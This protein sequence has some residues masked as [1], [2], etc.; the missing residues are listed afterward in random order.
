MA[1]G[2][3]AHPP[4]PAT[5]DDPRRHGRRGSSPPT[6]SSPGPGHGHRAETGR[7]HDAGAAPLGERAQL[8]REAGQPGQGRGAAD[9][10]RARVRADL[11]DLA[12]LGVQ[13]ADDRADVVGRA[14]ELQAHPGL[15]QLHAQLRQ[16]RAHGE[17]A[18]RREGALVGVLDVHAAVDQGRLDADDA[19]ARRPPAREFGAHAGL[20]RGEE[21]AIHGAALQR[22]REA[23]LV[24][25]R[26]L[27]LRQ[28]TEGDQHVAERARSAALVRVASAHR[29]RA[30]DALAAADL[31]RAERHAHTVLVLEAVGEDLQVELAHAADHQLAGLG[32]DA[33]PEG[34]V[35]ARE[36]REGLAQGLLVRGGQRLDRHADDRFDEGD[37]FEDGLV[38]GRAERVAGRRVADAHHRAEVAGADRCDAGALR[39][40]H[41]HQAR[42]ALRRAS[43]GAPHAVARAQRPLV[44]AAE[45]EF[46]MGRAHHLEDQGAQRQRRVRHQHRAGVV[47][48]TA[49]RAGDD[50]TGLGRARQQV[51]HR[52]QQGLDADGRQRRTAQHRVQRAAPHRRAQA[53]EDLVGREVAAGVPAREQRV[54]LGRHRL[55]QLPPPTL[56]ALALRCGQGRARPRALVVAAEAMDLAVEHVDDAFQ[57]AAAAERVGQHHRPRA[58]AGAQLLEHARDV[59]AGAVGLVDEHQARH[60]VARR[61]APHRLGLG[62]DAGD[63]A[64]H[65]HR[66]VEHAAAAL[67]LGG[68]VDV[69]GR[70]DEVEVVVAPRHGGD[71]RLDG[72]ALLAFEGIVIHGGGAVVDLAHLVDAAGQEQD[73]FADR[74]L[75][76]VDVGDDAEVAEPGV[77]DHGKLAGAVRPAALRGPEVLG[78]S[79]GTRPPGS[80]LMPEEHRGWPLARTVLIVLAHR[81][82]SWA[83]CPV[84][85]RES[86]AEGENEKTP[87]WRPGSVG[88]ALGSAVSARTPGRGGCGP[89]GSWSPAG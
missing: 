57:G 7:L 24:A 22:H 13:G 67:H 10:D 60:A 6:G 28:G 61:L 16:R 48:A 47:R 73:A 51:D 78:Q 32:V 70:V 87:V 21:G 35:L 3:R 5:N 64:E 52:I 8:H 65:R 37:P 69:A 17:C 82:R 66:P 81:P 4:S 84:D 29:R 75:A 79:T 9:G 77:A 26:L 36:R 27:R 31:G 2:E 53:G 11:G 46:A 86:R 40:V 43:V 33:P 18:G 72:D 45:A 15:E 30:R 55:D 68:E 38:I 54:G 20:D 19:H 1:G 76:A 62:L 59:G 34:R 89:R 14:V 23:H 49:D 50:R 71:R 80:R 58:Q 83:E 74:G 85:G 56:A 25:R 63:G 41:L 12:A 88:D 39:A 42:D 44:D